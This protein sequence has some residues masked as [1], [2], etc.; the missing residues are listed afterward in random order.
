MFCGLTRGIARAKSALGTSSPTEKNAP[1]T[2]SPASG[3]VSS[4]FVVVV[5]DSLYTLLARQDGRAER[6]GY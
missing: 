5:M 6:A 1:D 2:S 3:K 4:L